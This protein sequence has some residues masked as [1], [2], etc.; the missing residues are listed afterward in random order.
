MER[1]ARRSR[2]GAEAGVGT[3][4]IDDGGQVSTMGDGADPDLRG[5]SGAWRSS[6]F[7]FAASSPA[8]LTA[9]AE[10]RPGETARATGWLSCPGGKGKAKASRAASY[11]AASVLGWA[12]CAERTGRR[13]DGGP[14]HR[15]GRSAA[16]RCNAEPAKGQRM[17]V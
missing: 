15:C 12:A 2:I 4:D 14:P 17:E 3:D 10:R 16:S 13:W 5:V 8:V 1:D 7:R 11:P 9:P 6:W